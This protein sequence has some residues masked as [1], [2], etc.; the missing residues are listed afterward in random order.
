LSKNAIEYIKKYNGRLYR[1][2]GMAP[3]KWMI[4]K[5]I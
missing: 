2:I 3:L 4:F 1:W 5:W